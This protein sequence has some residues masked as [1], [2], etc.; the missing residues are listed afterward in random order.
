MGTIAYTAATSHVGG[1]MKNRAADPEREKSIDRGWEIMGAQLDAAALDALV[2]VG[3]DHYETFGL[4]NYPTFCLGVA[5]QY[6]GWGENN[7][8]T[9]SARGDERLSTELVSG[10]VTRD[11]DIS[12]SYDMPLDHSFMTPLSRIESS[13]KPALVP[14][15]VNCNT[16]PLASFRRCFALGQAI[17]AVV[18]EL[19]GD[20]RVGVLATGGISHWVGVP[21]FGEINEQ[22]DA[23]FLAMLE[24]GRWEE[25]FD[26]TD[27]YIETTAGNGALELRTWMVAA[28]AAGAFTSETLGYAPMYAWA[29]GIGIVNFAPVPA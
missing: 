26:W 23:D 15:F 3:T 21:R 17:K 10:L 7:T 5:D 9:V 4:K 13:Q 2:V 18:E 22:F 12:R 8:I 16:P 14:L 28:G 6:E 19:P 1:I 29:T 24:D 25:F 20:I 11:F 27:E